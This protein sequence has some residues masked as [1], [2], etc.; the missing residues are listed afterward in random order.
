MSEF[1]EYGFFSPELDALHRGTV[2]LRAPVLDDIIQINATETDG[3]TRLRV[4][5]SRHSVNVSRVD[6]EPMQV[7]VNYEVPDE[8]ALLGLRVE[9]GQVF[10]DPVS[11]VTFTER[12][13]TIARQ[14]K[15]NPHKA[16]DEYVTWIS[17]TV[18]WYAEGN[19]VDV[20]D[21]KLVEKFAGALGIFVVRKQESVL[22]VPRLKRKARVFLM[23]HGLIDPR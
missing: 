17:D 20:A 16:D 7:N 15:L 6:Q 12:K 18:R 10:T 22:K 5:S 2:T 11:E 21:K 8:E 19:G 3:Y 23:R 14:I 9:S 1:E 4:K 13:T